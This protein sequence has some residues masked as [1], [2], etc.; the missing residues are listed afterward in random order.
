MFQLPGASSHVSVQA[1]TVVQRI[2]NKVLFIPKFF[3][4][5]NKTI[6]CLT[7]HTSPDPNI[8]LTTN[9]AFNVTAGPAG[10]ALSFSAARVFAK[11][12]PVQ[13]ISVG[14]GGNSQISMAG[15][16]AYVSVAARLDN[17]SNLFIYKN[18]KVENMAT[19]TIWDGHIMNALRA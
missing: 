15:S 12:A 4:I 18:R 10:A 19:I 5:I 13:T 2:V 8:M 7:V 16:T 9:N 1:A 14:R 6:C 11:D 3:R 17:G